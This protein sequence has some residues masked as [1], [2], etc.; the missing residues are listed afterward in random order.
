[1]QKCKK[2]AQYTKIGKKDYAQR[3]GLT[4]I[5]KMCKTYAKNANNM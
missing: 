1:M 4:N 3:E 5:I 2:Y